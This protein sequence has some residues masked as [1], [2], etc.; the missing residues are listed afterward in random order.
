MLNCWIYLNAKSHVFIKMVSF[1]KTTQQVLQRVV[2][3]NANCT[4]ALYFIKS[5]SFFQVLDNIL[6]RRNS[7]LVCVIQSLK[8]KFLNFSRKEKIKTLGRCRGGG[9]GGAQI[10]NV[11]HVDLP[12]PL[13]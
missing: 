12:L 4:F 7:Y 11:L 1:L 13:S 3:R 2:S 6:M 5:L 8:I 10:Q 9:G